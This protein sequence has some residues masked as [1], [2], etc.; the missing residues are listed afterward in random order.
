[1]EWKLSHFLYSVVEATTVD[2]LEKTKAFVDGEDL[3]SQKQIFIS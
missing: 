3:E 1:M 2:Y